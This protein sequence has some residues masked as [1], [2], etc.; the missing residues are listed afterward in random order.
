MQ[1][2]FIFLGCGATFLATAIL[3][4]VQA[5]R[6]ARFA[7]VAPILESRR[8]ALEELTRLI[9]DTEITN[10]ALANFSVPEASLPACSQPAE[11]MQSIF[12]SIAKNLD[13]HARKLVEWVGTSRLYFSESPDL[14]VQV[15]E[16][17]SD[18][19][20]ASFHIAMWD[21]EEA[22]KDSEALTKNL[23]S[24][25]TEIA[26]TLYSAPEAQIA[27]PERVR[28]TLIEDA[29]RKIAEAERDHREQHE[30]LAAKK[31]ELLAETASSEA[32]K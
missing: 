26:E 25:H 12:T 6:A 2:L 15:V 3:N 27:L 10:G 1:A 31:Q 23:H 7:L 20:E 16:A 4:H 17:S 24:L 22:V 19:D 9:F 28:R 8:K 14:L 30:R 13:E 5:K 32:G 18:A 11:P 21:F 29:Q